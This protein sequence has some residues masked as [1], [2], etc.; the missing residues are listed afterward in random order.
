MLFFM[1]MKTITEFL[2]EPFRALY[3][4]YGLCMLVMWFKLPRYINTQPAFETACL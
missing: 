4:I 1:Y 2:Y 3:E